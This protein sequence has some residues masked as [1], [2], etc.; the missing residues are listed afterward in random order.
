MR[1][2]EAPRFS[3]TWTRF[4]KCALTLIR[5]FGNARVLICTL[6]LP[7]SSISRNH[8]IAQRFLTIYGKGS[9]FPAKFVCADS[10]FS[11]MHILKKAFAFF[12]YASIGYLIQAM[13]TIFDVQCLDMT[14]TLRLT[15]QSSMLFYAHRIVLQL[16]NSRKYMTKS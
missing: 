9:S 3:S 4:F 16:F 5:L 13:K 6:R 8:H 2:C 1:S 11:K 15:C 7:Q 10:M 14:Y 12:F